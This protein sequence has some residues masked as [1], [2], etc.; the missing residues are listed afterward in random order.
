MSATLLETGHLAEAEPCA[1]VRRG[2]E[3]IGAV[4]SPGLVARIARWVRHPGIWSIADQA[5]VSGTS[6]VTSIVIAR[7]CSRSELGLFALA[8]S[9]IA[10]TRAIQE[11]LITAPFMVFAGR[12]R[13]ARLSRYTGSCLVHQGQLTLAA[14]LLF[15][16]LWLVTWQLGRWSEMQPLF[17]ML[18]VALPV[19][20]FREHVRQTSYGLLRPGAAIA[21]DLTA[22]VLQLGIMVGLWATGRLTIPAVFVAMAVGCGAGTLGWLLA[23]SRLWTVRASRVA[24]DWQR[25]WRLGR[26]ALACQL[27]GQAAPYVMPWLIASTHDT[28]AAGLLAACTTLSGPANLFVTGYANHLTPRAAAAYSTGGV[29]LLRP[30]V[31]EAMGLFGATL[32]LFAATTWCLGDTVVGLV[33]GAK[34]TGTGAGQILAILATVV[35]VNS[36]GTVAGNAL[37]AME[38]ASANFLADVVT[39]G[40]TLLTAVWLIPAYGAWGSAAATLAGAVSGSIW[41]VATLIAECRSCQRSGQLAGSAT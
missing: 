22:S 31:L 11:Q 30:V 40:A 34:F 3:A 2:T 4:T 35:F 27:I 1:V 23:T 20:L 16:G 15:L 8:I 19:L 29:V 24:V 39:L 32:G 18:V 6:F 41:R 21:V 10:L 26:W 14:A 13:G 38:R 17:P 37:W 25:N 5:L 28:A 7:C 12:M 36:F 9:L 33:Y